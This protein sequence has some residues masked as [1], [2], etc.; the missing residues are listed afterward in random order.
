VA[1]CCSS[2]VFQE[3]VHYDID[4]PVYGL[5][6]L[7]NECPTEAILGARKPPHIILRERCVKFGD[8]RTVCPEK[9]HAVVKRSG[10]A[11]PTAALSAR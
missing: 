4:T 11:S 7:R 8:C 2:I 5:P 9:H 1:S 6:L 10:A 3:L